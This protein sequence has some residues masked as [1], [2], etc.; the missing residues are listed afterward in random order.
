MIL[1]G[2][3]NGLSGAIAAVDGDGGLVDVIDAPTV[4]IGKGSRREIVASGCVAILRRLVRL[5]GGEAVFCYVE[6]LSVRPKESA[7]SAL[8]AGIGGGIWLGV[9]A[10]LRVSHSIVRPQEWQTTLKGCPGEGKQRAILYAERRW[11]EAELFGP[12]GGPLDGRADALCIAEYG[13]LAT[14]AKG[15]DE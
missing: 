15:L 9:L 13:R 14:L 10:A 7:S 3:D 6:Q 12:R 4:K 2:I 8:K 5:G 1:I 11:P